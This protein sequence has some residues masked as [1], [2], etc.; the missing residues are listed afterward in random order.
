MEDKEKAIKNLEEAIN[1]INK[2][3]YILYTRETDVKKNKNE[4]LG[5][6]GVNCI[7]K[8]YIGLIKNSEII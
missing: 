3:N 2:T 5:L 6:T 8:T 1:M 4:R 7:L